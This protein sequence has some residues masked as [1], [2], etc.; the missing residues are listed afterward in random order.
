VIPIATTRPTIFAAEPRSVGVCAGVAGGADVPGC[1]A[2]AG[3]PEI[4]GSFPLGPAAVGR[5][6]A[7]STKVAPASSWPW[8]RLDSVNLHL[9]AKQRKTG[10][11]FSRDASHGVNGLSQGV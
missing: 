9:A 5:A 6:F 2:P 10:R 8:L 7:G 3:G 4:A 11:W 1:P